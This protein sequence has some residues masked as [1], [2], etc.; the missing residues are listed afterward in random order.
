MTNERKT[1]SQCPYC[2]ADQTHDKI[3]TRFYACGTTA[4]RTK[5]LYKKD[6]K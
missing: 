3:N 2:H 1:R 5:G 6:C 4:D